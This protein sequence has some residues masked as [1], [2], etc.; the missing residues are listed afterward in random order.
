MKLTVDF[1]ILKAAIEVMKPDENGHFSIELEA[2][3][4]DKLDLELALGKDVELK[5][6]DIDTGLL[7]YKG[8]QVLL[9]IKD[10][11]SNVAHVTQYP[12]SGNRF[13]VC[14]CSKLKSMRSEGRFERYVV[15]NDASGDFPISGK[16]YYSKDVDEGNAKLKVCKLCLNQL[17]YK[18]HGSGGIKKEIF[19]NF[20]MPEFFTTYSSLFPHL[21]TRKAEN[22]ESGYSHDWRKISS[23]YRVEK[24][25]ECEQCGV[26]LRAHRMLLH[27]H[28]TNG[29]KS[30]NDYK[31]LKALCIGCHS[32]QAFHS[33]MMPSHDE[34][35]LINDLRKEQGLLNDLGD[36]EELFDYADPGVHGVLYTCKTQ[37]YVMPDV[38]Y[39]IQDD[40][41]NLVSKI[42]LAW[43]KHQFGVAI[44]HE[45]REEAQKE[46]WKVVSP[47][48]FLESFK[49]YGRNLRY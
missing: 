11:G 16:N 21:P 43:G 48:E 38:G 44:S 22:A 34:R 32:K 1:L 27:V 20:S 31:N 29:V 24:D 5:D 33:H 10:H 9:Y 26:S 36:W 25:F 40:L 45:D 42:E 28:H 47:N 15:I 23:R 2:S 6:V 37:N 7:S 41:G 39:Y 13:H 4:I 19:D 49:T 12:E 18:G 46:G 3:S 14:D 17:N 35:Q 8:R 30:D